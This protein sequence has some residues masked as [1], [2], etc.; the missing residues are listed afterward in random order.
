M[1][2]LMMLLAVLS[3]GYV[4]GASLPKVMQAQG[5]QGREGGANP[6]AGRG[7]APGGR[8][9]GGPCAPPE[10]QA[11]D[12]AAPPTYFALGGGVR[13]PRQEESWSIR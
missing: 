4:A 2:R 8:F 9:T 10:R 7:Q 12:R 11:V 13:G 5:G 3:I 6:N 1:K